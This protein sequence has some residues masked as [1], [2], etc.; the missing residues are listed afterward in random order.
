[1][2]I[3]GYFTKKGLELCTKLSAG[4]TLTITR[5]VAGS[6][7][8]TD[9]KT[10]SSLPQIKQEL[11]VNTP[12]QN[13]N[14]ATI[15]VTLVA[16]EAPENYDLTELGVYAEDPEEGEILYKVYKLDIPVGIQ[17]GSRLVLRFYLEET[18]S[19]DF[20]AV[21]SCSPAGIITEMTYAP[22]RNMLQS[23]SAATKT[24]VISAPQLPDYIARLPRILSENLKIYVS[25]TLNAPLTISGFCGYGS[26]LIIGDQTEGC[27]VRS[28]VDVS[29][30][31]AAVGMQN[32]TF[33][34]AGTAQA[35][36]YQAVVF[37]SNVSQLTMGSCTFQGTGTGRAVMFANGAHGW[38]GSCSI[39][40]FET[41]AGSWAYSTL[42]MTN[43]TAA[44]NTYGAHV[45]NGGIVFLA[46]TTPELL[47]GVSNRNSDGL[48][49]RS[50]KLL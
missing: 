37:A 21:V 20:N 40:N 2:E 12:E 26:I 16:A 22:L 3:Q 18:L 34:D 24:V 43:V 42:G 13:G 47:G 50:G 28:L 15:P 4:S 19:E 39:Q 32:L 29:N 27:T 45:Y 5:I 30:C 49:T 10:V 38:L 46:G 23:A 7:E 25:G 36:Y 11:A 17:T 8:T 44:D 33:I 35:T 48:I 41:A 31:S 6:G 9:P 14:T 1:M